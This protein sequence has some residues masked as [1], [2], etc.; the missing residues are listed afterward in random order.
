V[1]VLAA[2][3]RAAQNRVRVE[4][5]IARLPALSDERL[6]GVEDNLFEL[7]ELR[8]RCR[9]CASLYRPY[10]ERCRACL[11]RSSQSSASGT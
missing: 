10:L 5:V 4:R 2:P 9:R 1:N 8:S 11:C 6:A 3:I 7:A